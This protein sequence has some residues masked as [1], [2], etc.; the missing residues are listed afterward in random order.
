MIP[1]FP[2]FKHLDI[3]DFSKIQEFIEEYS[4]YSDWSIISLWSWNS[5]RTCR[6][7]LLHDNLVIEMAHYI[8]Q[9]KIYAYLGP[10][11][12]LQTIKTL[13]H[14]AHEQT[15]SGKIHLIPESAITPRIMSHPNLRIRLDRDNFDYVY[16]IK[17]LQKLAGKKYRGKK[18]FVNRFV[19]L[20]G[21]KATVKTLDIS[22]PSHTKD[23]HKLFKRW[24]S[25]QNK[26]RAD[27]QY[28]LNAITQLITHA[29]HFTN[30]VTI[31]LYV[32]NYLVGISINST[33]TQDYVINHHELADVSYI[34]AFQYIRQQAAEILTQTG[35]KYINYEQDLGIPGMRRTKKSWHP[36]KY[37]RKLSI[38]N[39]AL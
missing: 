10:H 38:Q 21:K 36:I 32:D 35:C 19:R 9:E 27:T 30:L 23:I 15:G 20:Y 39:I 18:N 16:S 17:H 28:E 7:S 31:G 4:H 25:S 6:V 8:S 3:Q 34:G 1:S 29:S 2:N 22:K 37:M 26:D 13:T 14:F 24:E 33:V 11:R 12:P 5:G